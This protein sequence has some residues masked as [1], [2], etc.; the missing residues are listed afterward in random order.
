MN[1]ANNKIQK[2]PH[3]FCQ[4]EQFCHQLLLLNLEGNSLTELPSNL[5]NFL[6]LITL[7]VKDNFFS[8]LPH[9]LFQKM[10]NLRFLYL[11]GCKYLESLP[12]TF[13]DTQ[14]LDSIHADRLPKI[15]RRMDYRNYISGCHEEVIRDTTNNA[16]SLLDIASAFTI[17]HKLLW[18][19][20]KEN[21][22]LIHSVIKQF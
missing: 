22:H 8:H 11:S 7:N 16:P 14:R 6:N 15:F 5:T 9:G 17:K 1:L 21:E 18:E 19:S 4:N 10:T 2:I 20:V 13:F 3:R 12:T